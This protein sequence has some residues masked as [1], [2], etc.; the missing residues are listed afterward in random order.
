M[1]DVTWVRSYL[2]AESDGQVGTVCHC[3]ASGPEAIRDHARGAACSRRADEDGQFSP[4]RL[5]GQAS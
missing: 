1:G 3:R 4:M 5:R 2:L